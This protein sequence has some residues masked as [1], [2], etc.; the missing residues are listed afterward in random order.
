M[1]RRDADHGVRRAEYLASGMTE[2]GLVADF[3][4]LTTTHQSVRKWSGWERFELSTPAPKAE[5][6]CISSLSSSVDSAL[7]RA[8]RIRRVSMDS[9]VRTVLMHI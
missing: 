7:I 8:F 5:C 9:T 3:P 4:E 6:S 2:V 1:F